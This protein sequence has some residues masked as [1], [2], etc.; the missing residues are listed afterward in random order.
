MAIAF[1]PVE[2][3]PAILLD[4]AAFT[5][6]GLNKASSG[7]APYDDPVAAFLT[8]ARLY[9]V[10]QYEGA[11]KPQTEQFTH[12]LKGAIDNPPQ[13][14][15]EALASGAERCCSRVSQTGGVNGAVQL[16]EAFTDEPLRPAEWMDARFTDEEYG[17]M[18]AE[19]RSYLP[20]FLYRRRVTIPILSETSRSCSIWIPK[21]SLAW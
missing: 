3:G 11:T 21:I 12:L 1:G 19:V 7:A 6:R 15:W 20:A 5:R 14:A 18:L 2:L 9:A 8:A 10:P 4:I 17:E 13:R 16:G